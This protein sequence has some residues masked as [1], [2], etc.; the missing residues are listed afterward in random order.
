MN[1]FWNWSYIT[2]PLN[3]QS[4]TTPI[5]QKKNE[6]HFLPRL[7]LLLASETAFGFRDILLW[8][9]CLWSNT[10]DV[11]QN[12]ACCVH[13]TEKKKMIKILR[14]ACLSRNKNPCCCL[15]NPQSLLLFVCAHSLNFTRITLD[16][17]VNPLCNVPRIQPDIFS[18]AG[19]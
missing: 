18:I 3:F 13:S 2:S 11:N 19:N 16:Q 6:T 9:F 10:V 15:D 17:T 7:L 5:L 14:A 4:S 8:D 12:L 1:E